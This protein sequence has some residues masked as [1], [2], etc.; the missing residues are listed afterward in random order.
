MMKMCLIQKLLTQYQFIVILSKTSIKKIQKP[1]INF[2]K[3][4]IFL[5]NFNSQF[6]YTEAWFIE[7][8]YKPPEIENKE[9]IT[10]VIN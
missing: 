1:C 3:N 6:S 9:N 2:Y 5:K 10:L 8:N 7:Q 4:F